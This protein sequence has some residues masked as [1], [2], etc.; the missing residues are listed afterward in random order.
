VTSDE[1]R[2]VRGGHAVCSCGSPLVV[3]ERPSGLGMRRRRD[4]LRV[5]PACD[6]DAAR[7]AVTNP[8]YRDHPRWGD[9]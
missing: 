1:G 9:A 8:A 7:P 6:L 3:R 2:V 4:V 5:C